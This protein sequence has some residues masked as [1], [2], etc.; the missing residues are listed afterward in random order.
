MW[1]ERDLIKAMQDI[2][3]EKKHQLLLEMPAEW[4]GTKHNSWCPL[5]NSSSLHISPSNRGNTLKQMTTGKAEEKGWSCLQ[6]QQLSFLRITWQKKK[7]KKRTR[8]KN[9]HQVPLKVIRQD[10]LQGTD[11]LDNRDLSLKRVSLSCLFSLYIPSSTMSNRAIK[12]VLRFLGFKMLPT[13]TFHL[14]LNILTSQLHFRC[15]FLLLR[16]NAS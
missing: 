10:S 13:I 15:S 1:E 4:A 8:E 5:W 2:L 7:K 3:M 9:T 12:P 14:H 16:S 11:G 6:R